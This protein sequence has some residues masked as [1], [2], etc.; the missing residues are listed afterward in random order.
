MLSD[1]VN[2]MTFE[3]T[4]KTEVA[5]K[6]M[7]NEIMNYKA[8]QVSAILS[9]VLAE[10]MNDAMLWKIDKI[11]VD[12]GNIRLE[13]IGSEEIL[14]RFKTLLTVNIE[15]SLQQVTQRSGQSDPGS[16]GLSNLQDIKT[17]I[18]STSDAQF[19]I[20]EEFLVNGDLPWWVNKN[21]FSGM[22]QIIK[23]V[24]EQNPE[25]MKLFLERQKNNPDVTERIRF[26]C[27]PGTISLLAEMTPGITNFT[28]TDPF[29]LAGERLP[30]GIISPGDL[31]YLAVSSKQ[32]VSEKNKNLKLLMIGELTRNP[33]KF[34][35]GGVQLPGKLNKQEIAALELFFGDSPS[36]QIKAA[37]VIQ[38]LQKLTI[39]QVE[40]LSHSAMIKNGTSGTQVPVPGE[41]GNDIP[42]QET[43]ERALLYVANILKSSRSHLTTGL[44]NDLSAEQLLYLQKLFRQLKKH[45]T[46]KKKMISLLIGHPYFLQYKLLQLF[47]NLSFE[48]SAAPGSPVYPAA[49]KQKLLR[50]QSALQEV[51]RGLTKKQSLIFNEVLSTGA[52]PNESA[53]QVIATV[54]NKLPDSCILMISSLTQMNIA[55]GTPYDDYSAL[56]DITTGFKKTIVENAGLCILAPY[57]PNFF[58]QLGYTTDGKFKSRASACRALYLLQFLVNGR[59]RNYEYV[60]Q[61]N[62]LLCGLK[63]NEPVTGYKR[64]TPLEKS[65]AD[66]LLASVIN[67]W[68]ALKSTTPEG[69]RAS[70]LQRKGI[71]TEQENVWTLQVERNSY[72]LLL[73]SIPWSFNL[74]K[75]P[76]MKK[77]IQVEW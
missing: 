11:D 50:S 51:M 52:F 25:Y 57:L 76:W 17:G 31:E 36:S 43:R 7:R 58:D 77:M 44:Y 73:D 15:Q 46:I 24:I 40:F 35:L 34:L 75:L 61:L 9:E 39:F 18:I 67:H 22:D 33:P 12:L 13:E 4:C 6:S 5:A 19:Q 20:V 72:D 30:A 28:Y 60:L 16:N 14:H 29:N 66:D 56:A 53:K 23:E 68:Q 69:F 65:E 59:Q 74:I 3:F 2:K 55:T 21:S 47:A 8:Y 38:I 37:D 32:P 48:T 49:F 42:R 71:L 62:K 41:T 26:F 63:I 45:S 54:L 10:K 1:I 64:L 70:F 27:S